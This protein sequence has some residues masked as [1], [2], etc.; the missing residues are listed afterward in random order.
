MKLFIALAGLV[1]VCS[2]QQ[3]SYPFSAYL[4]M[5][6]WVAYYLITAHLFNYSTFI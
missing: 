1:A 6:G 4:D 2:T 3:T 5:D